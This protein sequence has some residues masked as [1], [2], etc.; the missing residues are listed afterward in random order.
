MGEPAIDF[1]SLPQVEEGYE[2]PYD[3]TWHEEEIWNP[4]PAIEED[5]IILREAKKKAPKVKQ[6]K[7]STFTHGVFKMPTEDGL[8][9]EKFSFDG[10]RHLYRPY[11]TAATRVLLFCARQVE[12]STML[13]N[14]ALCYM[15]LVQAYRV[16]YVSPSA[17]QTKTFSNDRIKEPIETSQILK[18]FTTKMLSQNILEK[19]FINR[20]KITMRYAFLNADRARGIP[21]WMLQLDEIQDILRDNIPVIEQ[22]TAHAPS[23]MKRFVYAGTPKSLDNIIEEYRGN[24]STQ[25]EWVVPCEGCKNWNILGE[26]NIGKK[27]P[28]CA[29]CGKLINPMHERA[30][31]AWQ[32]AWDPI[33]APFESYRI[34]QLMVPW[35]DWNEILLDYERYP[36]DKFFNE[37]LGVSYESGLRPLTQAQIRACC[38][39]Y[40]MDEKTLDAI[41]PKSLGQPFFAGIDWGTGDAAY[42]VL[43]IATYIDMKFRVV[44]MHRYVGEESDP[45]IQIVKINEMLH[46]FNVQLIGADWGFGFGMNSR[47]IREFGPQ[48]VHKFQYMARINA[49]LAYDGKMGRWKVHRSE[50]M[51]SIFDAIK[52]KKCEFPRWEDFHK[53]HATDMLNIYSEYNEKLRM[54][55]YDHRQGN[56]DDSFH[57]FLY[58]WLVSMLMFQRPDILSPSRE[59]EEGNTISGYQGPVDQG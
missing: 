29:K 28:I 24:Q 11:N 31:W 3:D 44:Y 30:Q 19:Q 54:I 1:S 51:A 17:T 7:P 12:K 46:R 9:Y 50:V 58:C 33:K 36:R 23:G 25:G 22:C 56:P 26:K 34:P 52:K 16:L 5:P 14:K 41:R 10:R 49:R 57:S 2:D 55:V 40:Q 45:E 48:R 47:L 4:E 27:G 59:D 39:D 6:V 32:V 8:T 18:R 53:P 43:T 20:S 38:K 13:G 35:K 15:S 21:A 37:V 42:T